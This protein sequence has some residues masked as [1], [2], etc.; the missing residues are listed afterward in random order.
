MF[1]SS[2]YCS[3][4]K[5]KCDF[6]SSNYKCRSLQSIKHSLSKQV[7][8][9]HFYNINMFHPLRIDF[10]QTATLVLFYYC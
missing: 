1:R 9:I 4:E 6:D 3:F 8:N 5:L 7:L 10:Y 2:Q